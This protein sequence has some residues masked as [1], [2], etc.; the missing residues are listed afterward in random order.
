[1]FRVFN[2]NTAESVR[3]A[4]SVNPNFFEKAVL[5]DYLM[6]TPKFTKESLIATVDHQ[7]F[8]IF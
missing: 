8:R 1:M 5:L 6:S 7:V 3:L 2:V 4:A